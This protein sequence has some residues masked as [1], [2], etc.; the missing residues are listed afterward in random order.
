MV[1]AREVVLQTR[2]EEHGLREL[3]GDVHSY[4]LY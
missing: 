4:T 1:S 3:R 2:R